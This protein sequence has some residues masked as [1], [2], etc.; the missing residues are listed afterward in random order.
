MKSQIR[1]EHC[2]DIIATAY[3]VDHDIP[4]EWEKAPCGEAVCEECCKE[5]AKQHDPYHACRFRRE[6]GY[7][8]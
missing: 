3:D 8:Q 1:C 5:C 4:L 2:G 6:A 7:D